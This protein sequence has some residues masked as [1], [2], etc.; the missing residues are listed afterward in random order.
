MHISGGRDRIRGR[1]N[2]PGSDRPVARDGGLLLQPLQ[3]SP[4]AVGSV[5]MAA[6]PQTVNHQWTLLFC[7]FLNRTGVIF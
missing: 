6:L 1:G 5:A 4:A 3:A 2:S 7:F